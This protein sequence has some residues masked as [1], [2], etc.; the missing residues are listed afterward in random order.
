MQVFNQKIEIHQQEIEIR[1][2]MISSIE[3]TLD[4]LKS[5]L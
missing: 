1:N 4:L 3:R 2:S 5:E